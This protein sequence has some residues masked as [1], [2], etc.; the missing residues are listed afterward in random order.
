MPWPNR[1]RKKRTASLPHQRSPKRFCQN[2]RQVQHHQQRATWPKTSSSDGVLVV[3]GGDFVFPGTLMVWKNP[4]CLCWGQAVHCHPNLPNLILSGDSNT[5][6]LLD[7][8]FMIL[9]WQISSTAT[10]VFTGRKH[11]MSYHL[12]LFHLIKKPI[13]L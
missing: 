5:L 7:A 8:R 6:P 13:F 1:T 4:T 10:I 12:D 9:H 11:G 3:V 2:E